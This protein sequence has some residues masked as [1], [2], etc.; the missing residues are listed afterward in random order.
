M[1]SPQTPSLP[2]SMTT[3]AHSAITTPDALISAGLALEAS[4]GPLEDVASRYTISVPEHLAR[5]I[6]PADPDDPI[7]R[8]VIPSA[9]EL[10]VAPEENAD[11][12]GDHAH[13]PVKGLV[14]RYPD[15]VLLKVYYTTFP[16]SRDLRLRPIPGARLKQ[17]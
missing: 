9:A 7:A 6:N 13:S 4:R 14:H 11:P 17:S 5:L 10:T 1:P 12:I 16:I 2:G 8:Q 3:L 15:R